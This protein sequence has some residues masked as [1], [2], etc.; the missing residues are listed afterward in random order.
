MGSSLVVLSGLDKGSVAANKVVVRNVIAS[1]SCRVKDI[2]IR[3]SPALVVSLND[4]E[5][6]IVNSNAS[7]VNDQEFGTMFVT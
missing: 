6:L 4:G 5:L 3:I 1:S 2:A 7:V